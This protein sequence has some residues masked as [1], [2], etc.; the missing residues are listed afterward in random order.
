MP[1]YNEEDNIEKVV[2]EWYKVLEG[3]NELSRLVIINDGSRDLTYEKLINLQASYP[4][5]TAINKPNSGHGATCVYGYKYAIH[6]NADYIFQTDSDGQ[7]EPA[8]FGQFWQNRKNY[9]VQIGH[10]VKR[11]DGFS[12]ILVTKVLKFILWLKFGTSIKDANTPFRLMEKNTLNLYLKMIPENCN[13]SNV[14]LTVLYTKF[15]ENIKYY[16][17][18][19][20]ERQGGVNSISFKK[21]IKIGI[22]ALKDFNS[23]KK[24]IRAEQKK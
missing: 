22:K 24:V 7:T 18:T 3:K 21:I 11:K 8:E 6:N 23:L 14:F 15:K 2:N 10:R 1:A 20:K 5:L 16:P 13:L 17:I 19:F 9:P 4:K 12:R